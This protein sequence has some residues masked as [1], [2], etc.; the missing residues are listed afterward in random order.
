[1]TSVTLKINDNDTLLTADLLVV[2]RVGECI[3]F[4]FEINP[5]Y[6]SQDTIKRHTLL[7]LH[8]WR[9]KSVTH[10]LYRRACMGDTKQSVV[11]HLEKFNAP[12]G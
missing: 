1:M 4:D 12:L 3:S 10:M 2:P 6:W 8:I 9:V 5:E 11:V 7:D